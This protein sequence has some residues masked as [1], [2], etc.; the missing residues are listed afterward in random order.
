LQSAAG[1]AKQS[2]NVRVAEEI[3]TTNALSGN[4]FERKLH[5]ALANQARRVVYRLRSFN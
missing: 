3:G 2:E 5:A 1:V 4:R